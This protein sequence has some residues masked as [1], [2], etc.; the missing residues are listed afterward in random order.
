MSAHPGKAPGSALRP[1]ARIL[2]TLGS[3]LISS[4]TVAL[5]ELVK[6]SYDA[7]ARVVLIRFSGELTAGAGMLEVIDDGHGMD[8]QTVQ[9]AW[10]EPATDLKK[11]AKVSRTLKRRLLGEKGIGRFAAARLA[12]ELELITRAAGGSSEVYGIFDWSQFDNDALY[13]DEVLILTE[14]RPAIEITPQWLLARH[15]TEN[16]ASAPSSG[17]QGTILRMHRLNRAWD[18]KD[19]EVMRRGLSRLVSP[20]SG[21]RDFRIMVELPDGDEA[22]TSEITPPEILKYPHYTIEGEVSADGRYHLRIQ[23]LSTNQKESLQGLF[24]R[25][26]VGGRSHVVDVEG[27]SDVI[28]AEPE[29]IKCGAFKIE[30]SV[31]DRDQLESVDQKIGTGIRSIRNDLDAIAGIN[32]YR[33]GFRVLPYGEPDNDW[34]RLDLRR[35]QTPGLRLS[36]NQLTGY[37]LISADQNPELK[38]QSN[39]EGLGSNQAF[40]DLH[41]TTL[42][43]LSKLEALRY[44]AKKR[45]RGKSGEQ[46]RNGGAL[47]MVDMNDLRDVLRQEM[48]QNDRALELLNQKTAEWEAK[49]SDIRNVVS[50]YHALATL[51]QLIDKVIHDGRQPLATIQTQASLGREQLDEYIEPEADADVD[52]PNAVLGRSSHRFHLISQSAAL[53]DTTFRRL[54]PLSGRKRGRPKKLYLEELI[55]DAFGYFEK[56]IE[57]L[58]INVSTPKDEFL[59]TV[60]PTEMKEVFINLISNSVYWLQQTPREGRAILV[61]CARTSSGAIEIVFADSGPGVPLRNRHSIF[62]PYFT[63]K[64]N[65][66]GLGLAI[67]GEIV[68]DYYEGSLE[69]LDTGPLKGAAFRITLRKRI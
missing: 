27:A 7:D 12:A 6:N 48:P 38:D 39:R 43:I 61:K 8:L 30:L 52:V 55:R 29:R 49:I 10:M 44:D 40:L 25:S 59:V 51:G 13:L 16:R 65:G 18:D 58:G 68:R 54:E 63:T 21:D 46:P 53:L 47:S 28:I 23:L 35:V 33:D 4:E 34:L 20:Y 62:D 5:I 64:P 56:E 11:K 69:L 14:E 19:L 66:V 45:E 31:W 22:H 32:I 57:E 1:R 15:A 2:R 24:K 3:D 37:I 42:L 50:R 26:Q 41:E 36:N 67:A 17:T 60:E 9:S